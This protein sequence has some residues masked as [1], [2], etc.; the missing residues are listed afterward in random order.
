MLKKAGNTTKI[1]LELR[2]FDSGSHEWEVRALSNRTVEMSIGAPGIKAR[3]VATVK[4]GATPLD[5]L[6]SYW[7]FVDVS[8]IVGWFVSEKD[9][10]AKQERLIDRNLR[11]LEKVF[12]D[13]KV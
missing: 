3:G 9:L 8:G 1:E 13:K 6:V 4:D 5:A 7:L 10:R 11:D 12:G 2:T